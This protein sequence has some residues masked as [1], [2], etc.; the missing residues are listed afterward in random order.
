MP[1]PEIDQD[2]NNMHLRNTCYLYIMVGIILYCALPDNY[3]LYKHQTTQENQG[4]A[5]YQQY[6]MHVHAE[7]QQG[8]KE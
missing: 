7:I 2:S 6:V 1:Q 8:C 4:I 3:H 5:C